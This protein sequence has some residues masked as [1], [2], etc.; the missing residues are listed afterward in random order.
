[1][2][3]SAEIRW[4]WHKTP[5]SDFQKWFHST[6][7]H[8]VLAGGGKLRQDLY[9]LDKNQSEIGLKIRNDNPGV[10]I[11]GLIQASFTELKSAPFVG[12]V[13][14]WSKWTTEVLELPPDSTIMVEKIR[15]MRKFISFGT[16]IHELQLDAYEMPVD[17]LILPK[18]G[19][20]VELTQLKLAN[21]AIWWTFGFEAFGDLNILARS[22]Q[23]TASELANRTP[24]LL[25]TELQAS[26][27]SWLSYALGD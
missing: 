7:H 22:I 24:P 5:N 1:M 12:T 3:L 23:S 15:W 19:C 25:V 9:L 10:E 26:Y 6:E 8:T 27:P 20:N 16:D 4:F 14:L 11:K 2:Q 13:D 18:N 17:N 21:G